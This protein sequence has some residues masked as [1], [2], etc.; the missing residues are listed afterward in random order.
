MLA[1]AAAP[2]ALAQYDTGSFV[3][4]IMDASGAAIAQATVSV[5]NM[6]TGVSKTTK[7]DSAGRY[8]VDAL[9][10]GR[11]HVEASAAGFSNAVADNIAVEVGGRQKLDLELKAGSQATTVEVSD[12]ALQVDTESSQRSQVVTNYQSAALPLVTRNYADL[13]ALVAGA[14]PT[15]DAAPRYNTSSLVRSGSFSVNGQRSMFNNFLLDGVDNNAYGVSN[16]GFDNQIITPPPDS[17]AQFSVVTNQM[18]AEYGR[19]P[20]AAVNV[21]TRGGTNGFHAMIYE[22]I[23]NTNLNATGFYKPTGGVKPE[24]IRNQ[25]GIN[26]GGPLKKDRLFYFVDYEGFFQIQQP[27]AFVSVPTNNERNGILAVDVQDPYN[28]T[29]YP[30]GKS[31]L[32]SPNIDPIATQVIQYLNQVAPVDPAGTSTSNNYR[33]SSRFTDNA[34]K[35]SLRLDWQASKQDSLFLRVSDR[36]ENAINYPSLALPIDQSSNGKQRIWDQQ[37]VLGYTHT[38]NSNQLLDVRV[39]LS[40]TKAGKSSLSIG[41][42]SFDIPGLPTSPD[43]SGGLPTTSI[44]GGFT[45]LGRQSTNPQWQNPSLLD[46]KVNYSWVRGKHSLKFGYE[47]ERLWESVQN[48]DP[49][50]GSFTFAGGFSKCKTSTTGCTSTSAAQDTYWADYLFG[51]SSGYSL[52]SYLVA[53]IRQ[54]QHA[55]YGEDDWKVNPKLTLNLGLRWEYGSPYYDEKNTITNFDPTTTTMRFAKKSGSVYD[56]TTIYPDLN[57]FAPRIGFAFAATPTTSVR[58]GYGVG[59]V[60]FTRPGPGALLPINAPYALTV[61]TTQTAGQSGYRRMAQGF[62]AGYTATFDTTKTNVN[63]IDPHTR[64]GYAHSYYVSVQQQLMKNTVMELAYVGNRGLKLQTIANFNQRNPAN[65]YARPFSAWSEITNARNTGMGNYNSLQARYEQRFVHGLTL[66]NSFT[67]GKSM[68]DDSASQD[69]NGPSPQDAL[70]PHA[71]YAQS[72]Y[73]QPIIDSLSLVYDLP[74][75]SGRTFLGG[76]GGLLNQFVGGWQLSAISQLAAGT[77]FNVTYTP[78]SANQVSPGLSATNRGANQYRPN[79]TSRPLVQRSQSG[80][81]VQWVNLAAITIPNTNNNG[82]PYGNLSRNP[83]RGPTYYDT[84]VALNKM[85]GASENGLKVQFRAEAYNL[86][87][88]TNFV[89]PTSTSV[90]GT[91]AGV[92]TSGGT[93]SSTFPARILQFGV[94]VIY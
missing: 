66:L 89:S 54:N 9:K 60:H 63:Y 5:T 31:I 70:N 67:W 38:I 88:R 82:S 28:G 86:F 91:V 33:G 16:Q 46:P 6:D 69:S 11:Y 15:T 65:N 55:I 93:L 22:F 79:R 32:S 85:F 19:G 3:G 47:F 59:Y 62:P 35:G 49:L 1:F 50:G 87:N 84:D 57:D 78:P 81:T 52:A 44:S 21:E 2:T 53:H 41:N 29:I 56:R 27:V 48:T 45:A 8:E 71:E 17:V 90:S 24:F 42:H 75:G 83:G 36:K 76:S 20:G 30:R 7:T 13:L 37:V 43:V 23:R 10:A 14:R 73:N 40:H 92:A 80:N 68:D 64:D 74:F 94:K 51:A 4:T 77:P 39:A 26:F 61:A 72:D 25:F 34:N 18:N 12:V 58:G